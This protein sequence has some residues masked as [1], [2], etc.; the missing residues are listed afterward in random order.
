MEEIAL[1]T[2]RL[3][4]EEKTQLLALFSEKKTLPAQLVTLWLKGETNKELIRKEIKT[5]PATF[6]KISTE[7]RQELLGQ[8]QKLVETPYDEVFFLKQLVLSGH[9]K[10]ALKL[11]TQQEKQ[12]EKKQQWQHLELLY[13]E[14]ARLCQATGDLVL[15]K[16]LSVKRNK[17]ARRLLTFIHLSSQLNE[18]LFEFEV[19]E[20]KKLSAALVN[21]IKNIHQGALLSKHYTLIHNALQLQYLYYSRYT[22]EVA[23]ARKLALS[24]FSNRNRNEERL[25]EIT[26]V[27]AS[28][29]YFNYLSIYQGDL[30]IALVNYI[31]NNI[32]LAG[33][34]ALFNFFYALLDHHLYNGDFLG[35][36]ALLKQIENTPDHTK[37]TVYR[38]G[39]LAMKAFA[40]S[41]MLRFKEHFNRF[42]DNP[43]R[44]DFPEVECTLRV[45]EVLKL[46]Q[47]KKEEDA[48]YKL[49][50]LRVFSD[51]NLNERYVYEQRTISFLTRYC[52]SPHKEIGAERFVKELKA[53]PYRNIRFWASLLPRFIK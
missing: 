34:H 35:V 30:P 40:E 37:F 7:A 45:F 2:A 19:Y 8:L 21:R 6:N 10:Q 53:A 44:M 20:N 46:I 31:R 49:N 1:L 33:S 42:Y 47:E 22:N 11:F 13:I 32:S 29:V 24:V 18:L 48:L 17:N 12:F 14:G 28:N 25:N 36:D 50:S 15:N 52:K 27:L 38:T 5:T 3:S 41:D 4:A 23:V 16:K 51:R 9:F 26:K 43:D 39:I